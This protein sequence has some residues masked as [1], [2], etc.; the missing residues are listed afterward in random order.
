MVLRVRPLTGRQIA[1]QFRRI[2]EDRHTGQCLHDLEYFMNLRLHVDKRRLPAPLLERLAGQSKN[3]Q[4]GAADER[5]LRQIEDD[6][7]GRTGIPTTGALNAD[8]KW[9]IGF[10]L[11]ESR[12][13]LLGQSQDILV[14][15]TPIADLVDVTAD[16]FDAPPTWHVIIHRLRLTRCDIRRI[17]LWAVVSQLNDKGIVASLE[18]KLKRLLRVAFQGVVDYVAAAFLQRQ[19]Q[20]EDRFVRRPVRRRKLLQRLYT[21]HDLIRRRAKYQRHAVVG[22]HFQRENRCVVGFRYVLGEQADLL[23]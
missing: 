5:Q 8:V 12:N 18:K 1:I 17:E 3:P 9:H 22:T 4:A 14:A 10:L 23:E 15:L 19:R 16:Q 13:T 2:L 7:P 6:V 21:T 11:K 20:A